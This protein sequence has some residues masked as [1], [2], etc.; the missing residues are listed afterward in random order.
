M[1]NWF[2]PLKCVTVTNE[3]TNP[4]PVGFGKTESGAPLSSDFTPAKFNRKQPS[5]CRCRSGTRIA[6]KHR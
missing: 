3:V 5:C 2:K 6:D 1:N 4:A